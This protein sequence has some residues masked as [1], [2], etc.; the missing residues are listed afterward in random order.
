MVTIKEKRRSVNTLR[1]AAATIFCLVVFTPVAKAEQP[2]DITDCGSGTITMVSASK[3]LTVFSFD[4]KGISRSNHENKVFDNTTFHC[5]GVIRVMAGKRTETGYFKIMDSDGDFIVGEVTCIETEKS[6][7][8]FLQG[9]G[10]WKGI[11]GGGKGWVIMRGKP[12]TSG[13]FQACFRHTGTIK[14]PKK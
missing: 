11:T 1:A 5:V 13:T 7:W 2:F 3:E 4:L 8:K 10:K 14:L 12:I 9:T 6:T